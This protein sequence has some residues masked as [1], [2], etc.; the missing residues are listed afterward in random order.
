[1]LNQD[2]TVLQLNFIFL[3][4]V[5]HENEYE[6]IAQMCN[7]LLCNFC[8]FIQ[9]IFIKCFLWAVQ[10][11]LLKKILQFWTSTSQWIYPLP[12]HLLWWPVS[13]NLQYSSAS[14]LHGLLGFKRSLIFTRYKVPKHRFHQSFFYFILILKPLQNK[15][16]QK[17]WDTRQKSSPF[18][19]TALL[20]GTWNIFGLSYV[21]TALVASSSFSSLPH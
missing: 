6:Y 11:K 17:I 3:C 1:M 18:L 10:S 2:S 12:S 20:L 7:F 4:L 14:T 16:G 13:G 15:K 8:T 19:K 21:E 9:I 5:I